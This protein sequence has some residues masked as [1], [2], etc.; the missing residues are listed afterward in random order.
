[1]EKVLLLYFVLCEINWIIILLFFNCSYY[2]MEETVLDISVLKKYLII[3]ILGIFGTT[4]LCILSILIILKQTK[5]LDWL[6][7]QWNSVMRRI[8]WNI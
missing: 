2:K 7:R 5:I 6:D 3:A 4:L 8:K 1:M